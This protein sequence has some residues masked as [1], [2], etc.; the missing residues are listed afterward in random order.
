MKNHIK[1][2]GERLNENTGEYRDPSEWTDEELIQYVIKSYE[3]LSRRANSVFFDVKKRIQQDPDF[4]GW[5]ENLTD[6]SR[7]SMGDISKLQLGI[8]STLL[9]IKRALA[10]RV[11]QSSDPEWKE[12]ETLDDN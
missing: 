6:R 4:T 9:N 3:S 8:S 2:F 12:D 7:K 1:K 5:R 11:Q 10:S